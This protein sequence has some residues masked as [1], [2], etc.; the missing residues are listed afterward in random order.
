M[1]TIAISVNRK[2]IITRTGEII[3]YKSGLGLNKEEF[4]DIIPKEYHGIWFGPQ[5][6]YLRLY[7]EE[8]EGLIEELLYRLGNIDSLSSGLFT[9]HIRNKYIHNAKKS[10]LLNEVFPYFHKML[11]NVNTTVEQ[12]KNPDKAMQPIL[13]EVISKYDKEGFDLIL[14][15]ITGFNNHL[16]K[17]PWTSIR[18]TQWEDIAKL[19]DLFTS[20]NLKTQ[21]GTFIDQRYIDY[22]RANFD[23]KIGSIHWRK[24][25]GLT[26]EFFE[27]QGYFVEIG[28]G[29]ADGGVD[30]RAWKEDPKLAG[31][32]T[33]LIQCKRQKNTVEQTIVKAL[34]ADVLYE[35]AEKGLIVTSS[36][37]S[38]GSKTV[39]LTR[40]YPVSEANRETLRSWVE[41]MRKPNTGI[42]SL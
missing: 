12:G 21:Y 11:K 31:P 36:S 39:C 8:F 41:V 34:Y 16:H 37:F 20:E 27:R 4:D 3:G 7:P 6:S 14:E 17:S 26:A 25:E 13:T 23:A 2:E 40:E 35:K 29:R 1:S 30:V 15:L 18:Q 28:P 10:A 5:E 42:W 24:F 19:N 32:P 22:I 33:I 38:P 9:M